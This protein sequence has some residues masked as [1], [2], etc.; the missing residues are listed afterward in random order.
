[1]DSYRPLETDR[2]SEVNPLDTYREVTS[3]SKKKVDCF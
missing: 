3:T 2:L 1:L